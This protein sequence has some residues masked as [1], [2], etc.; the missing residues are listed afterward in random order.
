MP[1]SKLPWR[2]LAPPGPSGRLDP[3]E[4]RRAIL[5]VKAEREAREARARE[6]ARDSTPKRA[7]QKEAS[8]ARQALRRT[9]R[10]S[11]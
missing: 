6:R 3:A 5:E 9:K 8:R 10:V 11:S 1:K 7:K 2:T 4:V